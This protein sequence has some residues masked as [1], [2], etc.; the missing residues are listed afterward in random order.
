MVVCVSCIAV[1]PVQ[2]NHTAQP[3][4]LSEGAT[5]RCRSCQFL[6]TGLRQTQKEGIWQ[7]QEGPLLE[8]STQATYDIYMVLN[9]EVKK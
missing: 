2:A 5:Q 3:N 4:P 9:K 8:K 1:P 6:L 7:Q